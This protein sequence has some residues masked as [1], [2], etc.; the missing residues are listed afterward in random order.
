VRYQSGGNDILGGFVMPGCAE[1]LGSSTS[2]GVC[3]SC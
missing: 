3:Y 2:W 1:E